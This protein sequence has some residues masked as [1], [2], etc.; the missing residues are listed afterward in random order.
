MLEAALPYTV[1]LEKMAFEE[2]PKGGERVSQVI[3]HLGIASPKALRWK[4]V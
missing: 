1:S 3:S 2:R 4:Y